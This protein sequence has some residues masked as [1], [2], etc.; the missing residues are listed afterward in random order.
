MLSGYIEQAHLNEF[1][2]ETQRRTFHSYGYAVDPSIGG[3]DKLVSNDFDIEDGTEKTVFESKKK[4]LG[5]K[6]RREKNDN[7]ED[8]EGFKGPWACFEDEQKIAKPN[9][10]IQFNFK[11]FLYCFLLGRSCGN[12]RYLG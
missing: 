8:V 10:V 2:F 6:R 7:P 5:D 9:E 1:Q 11:S 3:T 12:R 4:R